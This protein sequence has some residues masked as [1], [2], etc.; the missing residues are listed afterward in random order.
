MFGLLKEAL[1]TRLV[2]SWTESKTP[3][4]HQI[5]RSPNIS[6]REGGTPLSEPRRG[7]FGVPSALKYRAEATL[8]SN[9]EPFSS[10]DLHPILFSVGGMGSEALT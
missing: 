6:A 7:E 2:P 5:G 9:R 1:K 4:A 10:T 3:P 8:A